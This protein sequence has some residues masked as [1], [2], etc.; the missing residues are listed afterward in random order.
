MYVYFSPLFVTWKIGH[1]HRLRG[2]IGTF[3]TMPL[4]SGLKEYTLSR[5]V[6]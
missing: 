5:F 4:H 6:C 3:A 2:C 1:D